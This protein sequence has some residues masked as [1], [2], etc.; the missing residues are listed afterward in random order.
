MACLNNPSASGK[1]VKSSN[2]GSEKEPRPQM[3]FALGPVS[4]PP[5]SESCHGCAGGKN[6]LF[7]KKGKALGGIKKGEKCQRQE[8]CHESVTSHST[9]WPLSPSLV[10]RVSIV[11][12]PNR[13]GGFVPQ[14][15][16]VSPLEK[17]PASALKASRY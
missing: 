12:S 13:S 1:R 9:A 4:T 2:F 15:A 7:A 14:G 5:V 8:G 6:L 10:C 3:C 16:S 11:D 17:R